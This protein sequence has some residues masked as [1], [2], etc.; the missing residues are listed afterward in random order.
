MST[1]QEK[2][3]A[4]ESLI[5]E[6]PVGTEVRIS[7]VMPNEVPEGYV[8]PDGEPWFEKKLDGRREITLFLSPD[9]YE[10]VPAKT[11]LL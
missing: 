11:K 1:F 3:S 5:L 2:L 4:L 10:I 8:L 9:T 7:G 6:L